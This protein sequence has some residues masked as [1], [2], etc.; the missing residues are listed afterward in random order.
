MARC[1]WPVP[2]DESARLAATMLPRAPHGDA[3]LCYAMLWFQQPV[4]QAIV[5]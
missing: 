4:A 3:T 1:D 5:R 2:S